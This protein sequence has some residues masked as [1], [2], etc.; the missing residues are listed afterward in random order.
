MRDWAGAS[1]SCFVNTRHS[2][3]ATRHFSGSS[4]SSL[5]CSYVWHDGRQAGGDFQLNAKLFGLVGQHDFQLIARA[6]RIE[7]AA[8]DFRFPVLGQVYIEHL[9]FDVIREL[10]R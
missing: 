1:V 5:P 2:P 6:I 3:L 10:G 9:D 7:A 8:R 4:S